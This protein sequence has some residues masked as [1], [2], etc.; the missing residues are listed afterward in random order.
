MTFAYQQFAGQ[1]EVHCGVRRLGFNENCR[2]RHT[3][4]DCAFAIVYRLAPRKW[5]RGVW[6]I[7]TREDDT[8]KN[9]S[10]KKV[11]GGECDTGIVSP[12]ADSH[13]TRV[14][15]VADIEIVP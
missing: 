2:C 4:G 7:G 14:D 3:E 5:R 12:E 8:R 1:H 9:P 6:R 11:R 15:F 10:V 13:V